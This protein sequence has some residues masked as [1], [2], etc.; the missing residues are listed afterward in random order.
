MYLARRLPAAL[1]L[2]LLL[3]AAPALGWTPRTQ[4]TIASE[5]ARLAPPDLARQIEK[6][7][8]AFEAGVQA[9]FQDSDPDRHR[10]DPDG[11]GSLD[12]V[13]QE[14]IDGAITAERG[15]GQVL[16]RQ[17]R[18]FT[19]SPGFASIEQ[20]ET[21]YDED[22]EHDGFATHSADLYDAKL[23]TKSMYDAALPEGDLADGGMVEGYLYFEP[24]NETVENARLRVTLS[25][26]EAGR[27]EIPFVVQRRD[28]QNH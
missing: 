3:P 2:L 17:S 5:A 6:H 8:R 27:L 14:E 25:E 15:G 4:S 21:F 18:R 7:Q 11:S 9:P 10:K 19:I 24:L 28:E 16:P 23:P 1:G 20:R 22:F 26:L 13:L 12:R